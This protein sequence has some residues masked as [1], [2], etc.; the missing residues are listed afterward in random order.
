MGIVDDIRAVTDLLIAASVGFVLLTACVLTFIFCYLYFF[1]SDRQKNQKLASRFY[2]LV[3]EISLCESEEERE[4]VLLQPYV[5]DIKQTCLKRERRRAFMRKALMQFLKT[6]HGAAAD[7]IIWLYGRLGFKN[8]SL[9]Q[10]TSRRWHRKAA[11][12]Q[13]LAEMGQ[14]DCIT[15]IYRY[16]NHSNY[17]IRSTAQVAVVKLTGF[18]GLRFLNVINQPIT[19]WQ[20]L[21]LLQQ[22]AAYTNIQEEKLQTWLQSDNETVVELAL[23][24]VKAY[25]VPSAHDQLVQC[26]QHKSIAIRMEAITILK[27]IAAPTTA[28]VLKARFEPAERMEKMAILQSLQA[29]GS[30]D[31][32]SFLEA[33][34]DTPDQLLKRE[35]LKTLQLVAPE[36]VN[37]ELHPLTTY[38]S[39]ALV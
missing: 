10:L 16:T 33:L 37:K 36:W 3:S 4:Q 13:E 11:A 15:K 35:V 38:K 12:I 24:L 21:C 25:A 20:Q 19:H 14:Q 6:I 23:K 26:L 32:V 31:D 27:E 18:E 34:L 29:I 28:A 17:Y 9:Q 22:L 39:I 2:T 7:N 5:Q 8:D 30:G 1:K